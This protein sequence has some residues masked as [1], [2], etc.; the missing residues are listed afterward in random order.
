MLVEVGVGLDGRTSAQ[1]GRDACAIGPS[2]TTALATNAHLAP[3]VEVVERIAVE[4]IAHLATLE[5]E[6]SVDVHQSTQE[7]QLDAGLTH[8]VV[9]VRKCASEHS[10]NA[11]VEQVE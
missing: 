10:A 5:R 4:H 1:L 2:L 3:H 11:G 7:F 8:R 9:G 6:A